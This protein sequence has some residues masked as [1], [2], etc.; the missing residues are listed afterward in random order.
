MARQTTKKDKVIILLGATASGKSEYI[1]KLAEHQPLELV[2]ADSVQVYKRLD[3][4]SAKPSDEEMKRFPHHLINIKSF[5]ET[6]SVGEFVKSAN[7]LVREINERGRIPIISGGTNFYIKNFLFGMSET[8]PTDYNV[9][10]QIQDEKEKYGLEKLYERLQKLDPLYAKKI[11]SSD[12]Q[13]ITRALEII[14]L[15]GKCVS[16]FAV[17]NK[18]R[19]D[20]DIKI[21]GIMLPQDLLKKRIIKR[22]D[23]MFEKGLEKEVQ[24][25]KD[26]GANAD[27]QS[28]KG[29]GYREFFVPGLSRDEVREMIIRDTVQYAKRQR[30]FM[31]MIP[32]II[33]LKP[34]GL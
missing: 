9:R 33:N 13:R 18:I 27:M 7:L 25:L 22:V 21:Y 29:I 15:T 31:K 20:L 4:G 34:L 6:Y 3:I 28:M 12:S 23:E 32:N 19:D 5:D 24:G 26:D 17:P 8:P 10:K 11:S 1:Q 2:S 16:D 30:T 14:T